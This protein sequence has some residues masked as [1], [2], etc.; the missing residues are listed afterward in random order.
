MLSHD[1]YNKLLQTTNINFRKAITL[2][3]HYGL[4]AAECS[5]LRFEDISERGIKVVAG[6]ENRKKKISRTFLIKKAVSVQFKRV[7]CRKHLIGRKKGRAFIS[8]MG[9]SIRPERHSQRTNIKN[10]GHKGIRFSNP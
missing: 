9:I 1:D 8:A 2:S 7:H 4:R 10:I 3:F 5:K 6:R